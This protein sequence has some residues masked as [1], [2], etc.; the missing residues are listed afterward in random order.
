MSRGVNQTNITVFII[1]WT[2]YNKASQKGS[3]KKNATQIS[4]ERYR[5]LYT[6]VQ[7]KHKHQ[8]KMQRWRQDIQ[9]IL[10][11]HNNTG[12]LK[13]KKKIMCQQEMQIRLKDSGPRRLGIECLK[14]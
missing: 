10:K 9:Y 1:I 14:G 13:K 11:C 7:M 8:V 4:T 3:G 2:E 6:I 12:P 5:H